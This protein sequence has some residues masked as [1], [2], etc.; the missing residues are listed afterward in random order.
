MATTTTKLTFAGYG[1]AVTYNRGQ[2]TPLLFGGFLVVYAI[3]APA[4]V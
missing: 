1:C 4:E 2:E 3:F